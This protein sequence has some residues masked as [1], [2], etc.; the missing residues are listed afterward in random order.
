M[1]SATRLFFTAV[2]AFVSLADAGRHGSQ[3][4]DSMKC[5]VSRNL[6]S[7]QRP[8]YVFSCAHS[9]TLSL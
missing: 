6:G 5:A 3:D 8:I 1:R 7:R 4:L 9:L 2:F